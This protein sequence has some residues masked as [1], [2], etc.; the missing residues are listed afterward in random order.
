[1]GLTTPDRRVGRSDTNNCELRA[2][3]CEQK[4]PREA[5]RCSPRVR[6]R[7]SQFAVCYSAWIWAAEL[8]LTVML[9]PAGMQPA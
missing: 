5:I 1:M 2:A 6:V 9:P 3:S 4:N 7:S 8:S